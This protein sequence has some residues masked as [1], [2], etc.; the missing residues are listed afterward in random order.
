MFGVTLLLA[1]LTPPALPTGQQL[2]E[3]L[4]QAA[5]SRFGGPCQGIER[6]RALGTGSNGAALVAVACTKGGRHVLRIH[7]D[8]TVSYMSPC[9]DFE[10]LTGLRCF[11][12]EKGR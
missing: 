3:R 11:P 2:A 6:T 1:A 5:I 12:A 4:F 7:A 10:S 8:N 9:A